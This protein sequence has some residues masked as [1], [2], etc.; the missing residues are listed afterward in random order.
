[1]TQ[2]RFQ[3]VVLFTVAM[4]IFPFAGL[5]SLKADQAW[6]SVLY[7]ADWEPGYELEGRLFLHDFSYAG[8]GRGER[9]PMAVADLV[10]DVTSAEYGADAT[11][12]LDSTAAIQ[13]AIDEVARQGGGTVF[14]PE[15]TYRI[16]PPQGSV[17]ALSIRSSYVVLRGAG[18]DKTFLFNYTPEMRNKR[19]IAVMPEPP[20]WWHEKEGAVALTED[21]LRPSVTLPLADTR[22]FQSGDWVVV[23]IDLTQD[24]IDEHGMTGKWFPHANEPK[25]MVFLRQIVS[26][27]EHSLTVDAPT[28]Y[29]MKMRDG[30]RVAP[31]NGLVTEVGLEGFS[32]GMAESS[33]DGLAALDFQNPGTAGYDAHFSHAVFFKDVANGWMRNVHTYAPE[34]NAGGYHILSRGVMLERVRGITVENC[35]FRKPQYLGGGGNGYLFTLAGNECLIKD[36]YAEGG[37]HNF[38]FQKMYASGNVILNCTTVDGYLP[39]DFHMYLSVANLI[40]GMTCDGDFLEARYRPYGNPVHGVTSAENVFWNTIGL[41]Y[42]PH[43]QRIV[44]SEQF[45]HRGYIIGTSGPASRPSWSDHVE[46]MGRGE[47]LVP[48]SLYLDQLER[49]LSRQAT[50]FTCGDDQAP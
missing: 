1:M 22:P 43:R 5:V 48:Q 46:G 27:E 25:P 26:V 24:F 45:Q 16:A 23:G 37:R 9:E 12:E 6:R 32:I 20:L 44:H 4:L 34:G 15:G 28:R 47:H 18:P 42:P 29:P 10:I 49:R 11:G 41:R 30:A 33:K 7:P 3:L 2:K 31:L 17:D 21:L 13:A 19:V 40:D 50:A 38:T 36:C 39:S 14:M 35:D 8:Y